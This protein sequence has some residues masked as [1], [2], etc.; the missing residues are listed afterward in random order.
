MAFLCVAL[1]EW[2]VNQQQWFYKRLPLCPA[3]ACGQ[4][5]V[6][7]SVVKR[8]DGSE[9]PI[10]WVFLYY[11]RQQRWKITGVSSQL[12]F[13]DPDK[14]RSCS[15]QTSKAVFRTYASSFLAQSSLLKYFLWF[16]LV[17]RCAEVLSCPNQ[18]QHKVRC[19]RLRIGLEWC[20]SYFLTVLC[21]PDLNCYSGPTASIYVYGEPRCFWPRT[22]SLIFW[23]KHNF[24]FVFHRIILHLLLSLNLLSSCGSR[25]N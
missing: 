8:M 10:F 24:T 23:T 9:F 14:E 5:T 6:V 19:Q 4:D 16:A 1:C 17:G 11:L 21:S 13:C 18:A 25:F 15:S 22:T 2:P 3:S 12:P 20:F 7:A